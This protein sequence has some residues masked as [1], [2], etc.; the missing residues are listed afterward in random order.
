LNTERNNPAAEIIVERLKFADTLI[1]RTTNH[2]YEF[3]LTNPVKRL[4][5][6]SGGAFGKFPVPAVLCQN[7]A[8]RKG[9]K[10]RF[11]IAS[12]VDNIYL[13]TTVVED[14]QV[15]AASE[16]GGE[17]LCATARL[18]RRAVEHLH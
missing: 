6:L 4:G 17:N 14:L 1:L 9:G 2:R 10:L 8:P 7:Y 16:A 11:F 18:D 5:Y 13:T 12:A 15:V 3:T